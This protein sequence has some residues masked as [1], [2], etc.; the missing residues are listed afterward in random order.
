[1]RMTSGTGLKEQNYRVKPTIRHAVV[2]DNL[3]CLVDDVGHV[4][5]LSA[6]KH[7]LVNTYSNSHLCSCLYSKHGQDTRA[8][9]DI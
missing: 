2:C 6:S 7:P 1:M 3:L 9:A 8:T 5:L 4:N